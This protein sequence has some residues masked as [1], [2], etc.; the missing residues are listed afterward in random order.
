VLTHTN[1]EHRDLDLGTM[2]W[3]FIVH[4][5][6]GAAYTLTGRGTAQFD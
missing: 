2:R 5:V 1:D 6:A 4:N 3:Y